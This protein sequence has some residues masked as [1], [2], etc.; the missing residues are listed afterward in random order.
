[1]PGLTDPFARPAFYANLRS[2]NALSPAYLSAIASQ[3][4]ALSAFLGG[5]AAT[6]LGTMLA[7]GV[8][9]KT[10]SVAI[11]FAVCSSVAFIVAVVASTS[12]VAA[13]HPQ[14]PASVQAAASGGARAIMT[15]SFIL[16]LYTL[17]S[18]LALSGWSR[19]RGTGLTTSIAGGLGIL[20]V[21]LLVVGAG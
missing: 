9:G 11:G 4:G 13:M 12:L 2:M 5:F 20:L 16:G 3:L 17:L 7:L 10:A 18:S 15:L 6:F 21:S 14:A 8:R 1:M 19:S